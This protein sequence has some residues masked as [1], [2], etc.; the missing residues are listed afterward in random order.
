MISM[1]TEERRKARCTCGATCGLFF[2]VSRWWC[3]DCLWAEIKRLQA[4]RDGFETARNRF[5]G[6]VNEIARLVFDP[7][8]MDCYAPDAVV[9]KMQA[10]VERLQG[11]ASSDVLLEKLADLEHERWSGWMRW[12][13]DNWSEENVA[14]WKR[15]MVTSYADLPEHSKES[16]RKEARKTMAVFREAAEAKEA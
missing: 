11:I 14:R 9:R 5:C 6:A 10:E 8:Y 1:F 13:F 4:E 15:Q 16:D 7:P 3:G 2:K 12:M